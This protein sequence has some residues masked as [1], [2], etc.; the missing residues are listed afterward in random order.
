MGQPELIDDPRFN[1]NENRIKNVEELDEIVGKWFKKHTLNEIRKMLTEKEVPVGPVMDVRDIIKDPHAQA[2][3]MV[4]NAP[5]E[6]RGTLM[7]E[8]IFPKMSLTPGAVNH[9]G[10]R[11]GADNREIFEERLGLSRKEVEELTKERI[12]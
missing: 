4:I 3:E 12:I 11:L 10:K 9:A 1:S 2:R 5:D 7:M 8:G 6:E